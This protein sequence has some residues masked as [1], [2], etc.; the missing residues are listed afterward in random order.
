MNYTNG[1]LSIPTLGGINAPDC[2]FLHGTHS[3]HMS[4]LSF[5]MCTFTFKKSLSFS[6]ICL[7]L[8][9]FFGRGSRTPS[10]LLWVMF[11]FDQPCEPLV[12]KAIIAKCHLKVNIS[13]L[14]IS[15]SKK[16]T[17]GWLHLIRFGNITDLEFGDINLLASMNWQH[18]TK[19]WR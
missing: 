6:C 16:V 2:D 5:Q 14:Q 9:F 8:E 10:S 17:L 15:G 18:F 19:Q 12:T 7:T 13:V 4:T 3:V 11:F 1:M